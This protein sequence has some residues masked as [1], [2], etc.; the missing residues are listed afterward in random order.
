MQN[1]SAAV[2]DV[3]AHGKDARACPENVSA[4]LRNALIV[5]RNVLT[6]RRE[7]AEPASEAGLAEEE[8]PPPPAPVCIGKSHAA[9][10]LRDR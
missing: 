6:A 1:P 9:Y 8:F 3:R 5:L 4:V 7:P 2:A 10:S